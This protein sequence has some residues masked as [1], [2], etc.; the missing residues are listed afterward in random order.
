MKKLLLSIALLASPLL[1]QANTFVTI[2][3]GAIICDTSKDINQLIGVAKK[4]SSD[5]L[6]EYVTFL[7]E[8]DRCD[9]A[10]GGIIARVLNVEGGAVL[11]EG[12]T[13]R[14]RIWV[15]RYQINF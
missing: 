13:H 9:I 1:A 14:G 8:T 4:S 10:K 5:V 3:E 11:V 6:L 7:I 15:S 12:I 2:D